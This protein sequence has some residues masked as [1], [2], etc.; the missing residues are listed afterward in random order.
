MVSGV[1]HYIILKGKKIQVNKYPFR[2]KLISKDETTMKFSI[3][4]YANE[5]DKHSSGVS[6]CE[7]AFS[8]FI[9]SKQKK[10]NR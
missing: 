2:K 3:E 5:N 8:F 9:I 10:I 6:G 1:I 4:K 7:E